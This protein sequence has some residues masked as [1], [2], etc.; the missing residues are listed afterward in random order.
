M[1]K[2]FWFFASVIGYILSVAVQSAAYEPVLSTGRLQE[3]INNRSLIILDI[4]KVEE[5]REGHIP[6]SISLTFTA[7]RTADAD[8][9]CQLPMKD[10]LEDKVCS[11]GADADSH[12]VIVGKTDRD[13]DRVNATRVAWTL[14]YAG[15]RNLSILDGGFNKWVKEGRPLSKKVSK[16]TK[17]DFR[18][19][20]NESVLALKK[21]VVASCGCAG[22]GAI[23][24]TRPE[25]QFTGRIVCPSVKR[26]GRIPGAVNLPYSLVHGKEGIFESR[27]TLQAL[28]SQKIGDDRDRTIIVVCSNGQFASAW[29]FALSEILGY[30]NVKI[31]DGAMEEWCCDQAA[32]LEGAPVQ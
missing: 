20:W 24:D 32:P 25:A 11:M 29:W 1:K 6:G 9:G 28:A 13:E 30:G 5:Y 31:Y 23:L 26:K 14:R 4:R 12:V 7:W 19:G 22:R 16:R 8:M 15:I 27:G 18:C 10:E 17:S 3:N 2:Y 21:D